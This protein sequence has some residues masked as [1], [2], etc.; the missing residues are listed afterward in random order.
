MYDEAVAKKCLTRTYGAIP[1]LKL[2]EEADRKGAD[3]E[4]RLTL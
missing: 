1:V 4:E 3:G 2:V